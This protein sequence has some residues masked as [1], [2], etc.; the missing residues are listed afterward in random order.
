MKKLNIIIVIF[1]ILINKLHAQD[2]LKKVILTDYY[3]H[4]SSVIPRDSLQKADLLAFPNSS[5]SEILSRENSIFIKNYGPGNIATISHRGLSASHT[6]VLWNGINIQNNTLSTLDFSIIPTYLFKNSAWQSGSINSPS[7]NPTAGGALVLSSQNKDPYHI[8]LL[9][10]AGSFLNF[11]QA[12][13]LKFAHK[14]H[15]FQVSLHNRYSKNHFP[16]IGYQ[17]KGIPEKRRQNAELLHYGGQADYTTYFKTYHKIHASVWTGF[18]NRQ[19]PAP[20]YVTET[21]ALQNDRFIR[22]LIGYQFEKNKHQLQFKQALFLEDLKFK[23][24]NLPLS[25]MSFINWITDAQYSYEISRKSKLNIAFQYTHQIGKNTTYFRKENSVYST[26]TYTYQNNKNVD[27]RI[28]IKPQYLI[29]KYFNITPQFY[30]KFYTKNGFELAQ[31]IGRIYRVPSMND[32]FWSNGGNPN[33]L[34]EDGV[35]GDLQLSQKIKNTKLS[36]TGYFNYLKNRIIWTPESAFWTPQNIDNTIGAGVEAKFSQ[37]VPIRLKHTLEFTL[38]YTYTYTKI[39]R[40][41]QTSIH[42]KKLIYTPEHLGGLLISYSWKNLVINYHQRLVSKRY[43]SFDNIESLPLYTTAD[44]SINYTLPLKKHKL[45]YF[46][47]I[48]NLFNQYY[49]VVTLR[50]MPGIHFQTGI[51]ISLNLKK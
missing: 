2:T 34:P 37:K 36:A 19:I 3:S 32:R 16:I 45:T 17:E 33:L 41:N 43:T 26:F 46:G 4:S 15:Y 22:S 25:I 14:N 50:P 24:A 42:G 28:F 44:F 10:D 7:A 8:S 21:Y 11:G 39:I 29:N 27:L 51:N 49:E 30:Y 9:L 13:N 12:L 18:A 6:G 5:M 47:N 23:D 38:N 20:I 40:P 48:Q 1:L 31:Q 35:S